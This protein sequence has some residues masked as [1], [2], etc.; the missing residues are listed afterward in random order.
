MEPA[1]VVDDKAQVFFHFDQGPQASRTIA[2]AA[3][4]C[5]ELGIG[6]MRLLPDT[7][8][9]FENDLAI[10]LWLSLITLDRRPALMLVSPL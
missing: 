8:L 6:R 10:R 3:R 9:G 7:E 5:M 2:L 1:A 4:M